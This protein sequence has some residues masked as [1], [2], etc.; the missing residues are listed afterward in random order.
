MLFFWN[1][2]QI[3]QY[4][5]KVLSRLVNGNSF[6]TESKALERSHK[7]ECLSKSKDVY[8]SHSPWYGRNRIK[9][10]NIS[11]YKMF[12]KIFGIRKAL[13]SHFTM[14]KG[15]GHVLHNICYYCQVDDASTYETRIRQ[16]W[17]LWPGFWC[18]KTGKPRETTLGFWPICIRCQTCLNWH[19]NLSLVNHTQLINT[20]TYSHNTLKWYFQPSSQIWV[21]F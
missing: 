14:N 2:I 18:C 1:W 15:L 11:Y 16:S 5:W 6:L 17:P 9:I 19:Q 12:K 8:M 7:N 21:S 3:D 4:C 10:R 20:F 13:E